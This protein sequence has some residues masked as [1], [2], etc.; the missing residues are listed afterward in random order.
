[1]L[2]ELKPLSVVLCVS[3]ELLLLSQT[4]FTGRSFVFAPPHSLACFA[5]RCQTIYLIVLASVV[6]ARFMSVNVGMYAVLIWHLHFWFAV[7][8]CKSASAVR[9]S[10]FVRLN[11][12]FWLS[13]RCLY[14]IRPS[15]FTCLTACRPALVDRLS[16]LLTFL[17]QPA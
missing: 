16:L 9:I 7:S 13:H 5:S 8:I 1:M 17:P 14:N 11:R 6:S 3:L 10:A 4:Y 12:R 15:A 2:I